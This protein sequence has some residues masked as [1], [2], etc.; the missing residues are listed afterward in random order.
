MFQKSYELSA[1]QSASEVKKTA[2]HDETQTGMSFFVN[3]V[4]CKSLTINLLCVNWWQTLISLLL[5]EISLKLTQHIE[6]H[7][8]EILILLMFYPWDFDDS[9]RP[10]SVFV[11]TKE[12]FSRVQTGVLLTTS[13]LILTPKAFAR[14]G[15]V[16]M[17]G[18][19]CSYPPVSGN[20]SV[21]LQ[22]FYIQASF[23]VH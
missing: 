21:Y 14:N 8:R 9:R 19:T 20:C 13:K 5:I 23:H 16:T 2:A 1:N 18:K 11:H 22:Q 10:L 17:Y 12:F 4:I 6:L 7:F 3:Y 15:D